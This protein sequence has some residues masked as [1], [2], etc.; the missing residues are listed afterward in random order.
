MNILITG[1]TGFVGSHILQMLLKDGHAVCA[2]IRS[3][4]RTSHIEALLN[5]CV[6][7][8]LDKISIDQIY[9][10]NNMEGVIPSI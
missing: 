3:T 10:Q 5:Q 1:A 8:N 9:R 7:C 4:S 6:V 2:T